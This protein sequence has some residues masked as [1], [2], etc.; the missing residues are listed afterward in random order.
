MESV[1]SCIYGSAL[2]LASKRLIDQCDERHR[3]DYAPKT[4]L[5]PIG[6]AELISMAETAISALQDCTTEEQT[7]FSALVLL[8]LRKS[9]R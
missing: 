3:A 1:T 2:T 7:A 8:K 6:A 4:S 5:S 9:E